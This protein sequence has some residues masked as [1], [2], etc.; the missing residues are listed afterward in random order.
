MPE[1]DALARAQPRPGRR[2]TSRAG[3]GARSRS[4]GRGAPAADK[5]APTP[6]RGGRPSCRSNR[7]RGP[8]RD[9]SRISGLPVSVSKVDCPFLVELEGSGTVGVAPSASLRLGAAGRGPCAAASHTFLPT[10]EALPCPSLTCLRTSGGTPQ[11]ALL[12]CKL[13]I[14]LVS[15]VRNALKSLHNSSA[16]PSSDRPSGA[17]CRVCR[18]PRAR[19]KVAGRQGAAAA[20]RMRLPACRHLR[21]A[22]VPVT[23]QASREGPA[24]RQTAP[25]PAITA[26]WPVPTPTGEFGRAS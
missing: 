8:R 22:P 19:S 23:S 21:P 25:L 24:C 18:P 13:L 20:A 4:A 2:T 15:A 1:I 5:A 11:V 14:I 3:A 10:S 17:L 6:A 26:G 16:G 12:S 7:R 9:S